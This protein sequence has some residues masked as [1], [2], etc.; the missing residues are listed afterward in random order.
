MTM[1]M[2]KLALLITSLVACGGHKP[3]DTTPVE[4][5]G[6][7]QVIDESASMIPPEK[8]DEIEH[9]LSRKNMIISTCLATAMEAKEVPRGTHGHVTFEIKIATDGH[10]TD[11][12]VIKTDIQAADVI[13][14]A[15]KHVLD[16]AFPTLPKE[17]E[18][19]HSFAMEA[20]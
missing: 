20:N 17:Y 2:S 3:A 6:N 4:P 14:C 1:Q 9:E 5:T 12:H 19:S 8:M 16:I 18:T 7:P 13:E 15:K 11:I 10:A